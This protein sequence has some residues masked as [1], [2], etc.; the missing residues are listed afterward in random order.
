MKTVL[1]TE[2]PPAET[3]FKCMRVGDVVFEDISPDPELEPEW[4]ASVPSG[5]GNVTSCEQVEVCCDQPDYDPE[6]GERSCCGCPDL[7]WHFV[8]DGETMAPRK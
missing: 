3:C 1:M 5:T 8:V 7:P 2:Q 4:R 6:T